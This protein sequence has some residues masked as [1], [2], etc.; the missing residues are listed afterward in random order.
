MLGTYPESLSCQIALGE[1]EERHGNYQ[2]AVSAC[3]RAHMFRPDADL[4][5][6]KLIS[7]FRRIGDFAKAH[8]MV[9]RFAAIDP[10]NQ[11]AT[12]HYRGQIHSAASA[13][14]A[15]MA[16]FRAGLDC[17]PLF[18]ACTIDLAGELRRACRLGEAHAA[19]TARPLTYGLMMALSDLELTRRDH[20]TAVR[21]AQ[22]AHALEPR[23]IDPLLRLA[24]IAIDRADFP[25]AHAAAR[26]I[27]SCG[28]E[29]RLAAQR[30]RLDAFK[31]GGD[32]QAAL[33]ILQEM[34]AFQAN[35]ATILAEL[36]RQFRLTGDRIAAQDT[37]ARA[38][39]RE[40]DNM[41]ALTE[42][43]DQAHAL[44]DRHA[45]L[46]YARRLL[47]LGPDQAGRHLRVARILY[48]LGEEQEALSIMQETAARFGPTA[49]IWGE[50]IRILRES[51]LIHQA[52]DEARAANA[53]HPANFGRWSDCFDLE[54]KLS[55]LELAE[56][57]LERAPV[58][59]R[60]E[61]V[62]LLVARSRFSARRH[63]EDLA[64]ELLQSALNRHPHNRG[65]L[66]ELLRSN[67]KNFDVD[68]ARLCRQRLAVLDAPGRRFRGAT[69]NPSQSHE[70][71][72]LND[73]I[74]DRLA[75]EDLNRV[76]GL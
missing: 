26:S 71:Q 54:L 33:R 25:A 1:L 55:P 19:L 48:D 23:K 31:S 66:S 65:I 70:G 3:H 14:D 18:E 40:P 13:R 7:L 60:G 30:C 41:A 64:R 74:L 4:P 21:H 38:L 22:A 47:A 37:L 67:L 46:G 62:H 75:T 72:M 27:E 53:A 6:R 2:P 56:T 32:E 57:C 28:A 61:E 24:R 8:V 20:A 5:L 68:D 35:E 11:A 43:C 49:E 29:H 76:K 39:N 34:A 59:S 12:W 50:Q 58:Q 9:D 45:A 10:R 15:A 73:M 44:D 42:A 69:P 36:A 51:G 63:Q 17:D 52:L 16:A